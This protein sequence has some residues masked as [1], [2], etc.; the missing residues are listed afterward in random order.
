[1]RRK[2]SLQEKSIL[3]Q[4]CFYLSEF[5]F[6]RLLIF[7]QNEKLEAYLTLSSEGPNFPSSEI[8]LNIFVD[9]DV[10]N[11]G[12]GT[13]LI[14]QAKHVA[15][16]LGKNKITIMVKKYRPELYSYYE[17]HGFKLSSENKFCWN[18]AFNLTV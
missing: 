5:I 9:P 4:D 15:E 18:M 14:N 17:K 7:E 10:Q 11:Q 13:R 3:K 2:V 6:D 16:E 12:H 1:M 8:H